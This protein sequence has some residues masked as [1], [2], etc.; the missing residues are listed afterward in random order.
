MGGGNT[1]LSGPDFGAG[2]KVADVPE[3]EPLLGHAQGEAVVL[4]RKGNEAFAVG[5]SCTHYGGPL[6][7]GIVEGDT[8]RCP[9]H[10]ACFSLRTG[11][12]LHAPA[13][14][15]VACWSVERQADKLVVISKKQNPRKKASGSHPKQI[16]ILG[17]GAAGQAA[18]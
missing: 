14:N 5:A 16:V 4:V 6:S 1:E 12:A 10:H 13:L 11:E 3:G 2:V 15:D 7:E 18:A 17:G 8:I 9:W